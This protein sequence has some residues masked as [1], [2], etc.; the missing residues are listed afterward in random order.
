MGPV[1]PVCVAL[2]LAVSTVLLAS[3]LHRDSGV[4]T[5]SLDDP[6]I[7]LALAENLAHD[8]YGINPGEASSPSSSIVW[9]FLLAP[10]ARVAWGQFVPLVLN[11]IF[12][13]L[14]A[15]R[16]GRIVE[17]WRQRP[18]PGGW[19][20][21]SFRMTFATALMLCA[22]LWGL[23][24]AGME[25]GLQVLLAVVCAEGLIDGF[26][27]RPLTLSCL[28]AAALA[29]MVRYED[30]ALTGAVAIVLWGQG[31][32]AAALRLAGASLTGPALFSLFLLSR[33][34]PVLPSSV[35][36]KAKAYSVAGG[37]R[38][39]V[40]HSLYWDEG[41]GTMREYSWWA[42]L[43]AALVLFGLVAWKR[44]R[45][46][47]FVLVAAFSTAVLQLA[48]GRFNWFHRYEVYA[49]AFVALVAATALLET[50]RVWRIVVLGGLLALAHPYW[51]ALVETPA[52]AG[53]VYR[54]QYQMHRFVADFY[55][56]SVA[57]NDIGLVSYRRP[58]EVYVLDLWGLASPEA[59]RQTH[60]N[61]DWLESTVARHGVGLAMIYPN[62][63]EEG[64]PDDWTGI[65]TLC[66]AGA[67]VSI[68][69]PC[70]GF[71][72]TGLGD[73]AQLTAAL[74][75]FART[76]PAGVTINLGPPPDQ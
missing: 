19:T 66:I 31:R 68:A 75:A 58:P 46:R 56:R 69:E 64:A 9:P 37:G 11:L 39:A 23:T 70:V 4:F 24:F 44:Q 17:G 73:H 74:A 38:W 51:Q 71:F 59:S 32:L 40:L 6:Y 60:K 10:F 35:L 1:A 22:N 34:L 29:P 2:Y 42:L 21:W 20:G 49:V 54:Q 3:I 8:H 13:G 65:A 76:A 47:R 28:A 72:D 18:G 67:P 55:R 63:Y 62:W 52:A 53:D 43:A 41:T 7:H 50:T 30:F 57:V 27:G 5:Y 33:G 36:V 26:A 61:V 45:A 16:I 15:W 25:H 48:V 12:C 14:A